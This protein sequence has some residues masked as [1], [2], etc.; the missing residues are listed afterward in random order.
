MWLEEGMEW[1]RKRY[2]GA[3]KNGRKRKRETEGDRERQGKERRRVWSGT[4]EEVK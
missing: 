4:A 3:G 1:T 2:G